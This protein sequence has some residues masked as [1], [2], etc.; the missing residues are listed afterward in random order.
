MKLSQAKIKSV[1]GIA[2]MIGFFLLPASGVAQDST[3]IRKVKVLPVPA[4]GYSPET[5]SYFGVVTL[6]TFHFYPDSNTRVSNA[7]VEFNYTQR[8]QIIVELGWNY[9]TKAEKWFTK[10][11]LHFSKY[12]DFYYGIG[13]ETADS[14]KLIFTSHRQI[15]DLA[16]YRNLGKHWFAGPNFRYQNYGRLSVAAPIPF[17][18]ELQ[19]SSM[20]G[21][22]LA[23]LHDTRNNLLNATSGSYF[24]LNSALN[25]TQHAYA[26]ISLDYRYYKSWKS[27]YTLASRIYNE[28]NTS[29]P[30]FYDLAY[31]GG[32][33]FVRG[34]YFGR[35]RDRNLS[36]IQT[37]LRIP[38]FWR[39]GVTFFGGLSAVY[40]KIQEGAIR[41]KGNAGMGLR[42]MMDKKDKTNLRFDYAIG[43]SKNSGFY[44]AF[45]E[46][47]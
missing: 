43:T 12:P 30:P 16:L 29:N 17:Y 34:Y 36:T 40:A 5:K 2:C 7:K 11:L 4:F 31:L 37:E 6:F 28:F 1:A 45:G 24:Y 21:A 35:F 42:I 18:T 46:S 44:V 14:Q 33:K 23:L 38:L 10:G 39:L 22:G 32:D 25:K 41:P 20:L 13:S 19:P 27:R 9:F 26:K 8:K 47:F 15:I 3:R